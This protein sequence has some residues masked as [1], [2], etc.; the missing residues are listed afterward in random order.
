MQLLLLL[1]FSALSAA[2]TVAQE[3]DRRTFV[4]LL[5]TDLRNYEIVVGKLLGSLLQI[6]LFL[7]GS[8]PVLALLLLLGGI[9]YRQIIQATLVLAT[10]ALAALPCS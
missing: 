5:L 2:S 7:A 10:T 1:F 3:K 9:D 8:V 4:L 6:G